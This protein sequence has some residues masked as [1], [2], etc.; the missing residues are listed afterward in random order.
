MA[1]SH[2]SHCVLSARAVVVRPDA[3]LLPRQRANRGHVATKH[4]VKKGRVTAMQRVLR[5]VSNGGLEPEGMRIPQ[6]TPASDADLLD[7][8][9]R[10]VVSAAEKVSPAVV[11]IDV[12]R[13]LR[14]KRAADPR[15]SPEMRGNGSGFIFTPD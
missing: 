15:F 1:G 13:Q 9:S 3:P 7:A 2:F 10:A 4:A 8:Y 12:H 14:N 11:N 6:D 5:L